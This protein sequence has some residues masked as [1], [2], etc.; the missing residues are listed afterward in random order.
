MFETP[1]KP[2]ITVEARRDEYTATF[3]VRSRR[4]WNKMS[5]DERYQV[6]SQGATA[7]QEYAAQ[8]LSEAEQLVSAGAR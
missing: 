4:S 2:R 5:L 6:L 3:I 8:M 7:L 1:T